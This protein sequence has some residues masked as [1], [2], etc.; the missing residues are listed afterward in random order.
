VDTL[1]VAI[2]G[3]S[4]SGKTTLIKLLAGLF[5]PTEGMILFDG[6]ELRT[7]DYRTLRRHVGFVLQEKLSLR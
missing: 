7:L 2:V 3:R 4:G 1:S 6:L 5:E